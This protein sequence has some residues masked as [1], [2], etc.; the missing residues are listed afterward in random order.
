MQ[1][2]ALSTPRLA[3][4]SL[5]EL[6]PHKSHDPF[7]QAVADTYLASKA[8]P[9]RPNPYSSKALQDLALLNADGLTRTHIHWMSPQVLQKVTQDR[10]WEQSPEGYPIA[11][12][13]V[14]GAGPGGLATGYHLAQGGAR[15]LTLEGGYA[16]QAFSDAGA[17]SVHAMRTNRL[18][19]SLIRTGRALE[20][21][22]TVMG[23]PA[24]LAVL[25]HHAAQARHGLTERTGHQIQGVAQGQATDWNVPAS[26]GELFAHFQQVADYLASGSENSFLIEQA[27]VSRVERKGDLIYLE[28]KPGHVVC[29]RKLVL[30]T[31]LVTPD[32]ANAR[33]PECFRHLA[34]QSPDQFTLLMDDQASLEPGKT[35]IL[36]D[37]LLGRPEV[38]QHLRSLPD[39]SSVAV[40][41][42]GESAVKGALEVLYQNDKLQVH[43][44]TKAPLEV[45]QVQIPGENMHPVVLENALRDSDYASYSLQR[46]AEL[47]GTPITPRTMIELLQQQEAGRL[48]IYE[49]GQNFDLTGIERQSDGSLLVK[50]DEMKQSLARQ[51]QEYQASG[52][53]ISVA[54]QIPEPK[55]WISAIG[56][57]SKALTLTELS[58][59]LL[60]QG[61]IEVEGGKPLVQG[62]TSKANSNVAFNTAGAPSTAADTS[63]PG[64]AVRGRH[65]A[66]HLL[67]DLPKRPLPAQAVPPERPGADWANGYSREDF[68]GFVRHRGLAPNWAEE[69]QGPEKSREVQAQF[70][71]PD[72]E[73]FLRGLAE[74]PPAQLSPVERVTLE[75]ARRLQ[76]RMGDPNFTEANQVVS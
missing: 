37:R 30:S 13:V 2:H 68:L 31:G 27:P 72:P 12:V 16:G 8:D 25:V 4:T 26:R 38:Q 36:V 46:N 50:N 60:H 43:L 35:P 17:G 6:I 20:D 73:R 7:V 62:L 44:F 75:R 69:N 29:C 28:T 63:I 9:A 24:N 65:L 42:S 47:F 55:A 34:Q 41:G 32:G 33:I 22:A 76:R 58:Q 39:G 10:G 14:V 52:L 71:F 54:N 40:V 70:D 21:L 19:T 66:K 57:D 5:A 64:M 1:V 15:V 23:L 51:Q 49:L 53:R 11:D 56:Y 74:R 45:A 3:T 59:Q 48:H 61:L 67:G 18:A